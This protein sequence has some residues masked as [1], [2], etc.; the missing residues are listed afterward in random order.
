MSRARS[1][2][3][4]QDSLSPP[5][6]AVA[7]RAPPAARTVT[8]IASRVAS[9]AYSA[10]GAARSDETKIGTPT[11]APV[12]STASASSWANALLPLTSCAR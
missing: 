9:S 12:A 3:T 11:A 4:S 8:T 5:A 2:S 7:G 6:L 1:R 10:S